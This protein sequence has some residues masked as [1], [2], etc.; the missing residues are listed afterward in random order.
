[1]NAVSAIDLTNATEQAV[2]LSG[3]LEQPTVV[4]GALAM[5]AHGY[6]RET[7]DVDIVLAVVVGDSSG[8]AL[9]SVAQEMGLTLR[10]KHGFGG[11][12]L[13]A[14][15]V[16]IDVL[17]LDRDVPAL[18]P[19]AV[20]EAVDSDRRTVLFGH[21]VFVVS[22]GHLIAMKLVAERKKDIADIVEL[23][24]VRLEA[25]QWADDRAEVKEVVKRHLGWYAA[26]KVDDLVDTAR[27]ELGG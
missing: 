4:A 1:M 22:L 16:R 23:I 3:A 7:S 15:A 21:D 26:R 18:V 6:R 12:D 25:G 8:D 19:E 27:G 9:E 11:Y 14:G 13:R 2:V 10:A 24:K 20:K 17:T 5:A